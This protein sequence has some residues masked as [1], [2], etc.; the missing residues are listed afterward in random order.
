[1]R[2]SSRCY[3][4]IKQPVLN[5]WRVSQILYQKMLHNILPVL[6]P[7]ICKEKGKAVQQNARSLSF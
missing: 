7:G 1:M 6:F 3:P 5:F 4:F 2:N